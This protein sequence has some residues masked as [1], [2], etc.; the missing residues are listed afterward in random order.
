MKKIFLIALS[1]LLLPACTPTVKVEAPDKPIEINMNVNI[2]H[3]VKVEIQ[4]DVKDAINKNED[5]F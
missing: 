3:R 1:V 2:E 5:I 4:R